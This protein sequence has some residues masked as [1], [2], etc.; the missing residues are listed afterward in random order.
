MKY[1]DFKLSNTKQMLADAL[2]KGY[3]VPGYNFNNLEGLQA[4]LQAAARTNSPVILQTS[5]GAIEYMGIDTIIGMV[6]GAIQEY[7]GARPT[8]MGVCNTPLQIALHLDHGADFDICKMC[9]DAGYSSVMIDGSRL[10]FDENVAVSRRVAEY[11]H[12]YDVSVEA[13]LGPLIGANK[14]DDLYT[15]PDDALRFVNETGVDSLAVSIG[16]SHGAYK[17]KSPVDTLR[18]DILARIAALLPNTPLV[19]HGASAIPQN[20]ITEINANGGNITGARGIP[21]DQVITARAHHIAKVNIDSDARLA[22]TA[23]V[24]MTLA[25]HPDT[26]DPRDYMGAA[27]DEMIKFYSDKNINVMGCA[28]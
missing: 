6:A 20:Y 12:K 15:N 11:A 2:S 13:E 23:A 8:D 28:S 3:A 5:H 21:D 1:S 14:S 26:F 17:M 22:T 4:I 24:R 19:L 18:F 7:I 10:S 25:T 9:V 27:R 16:T